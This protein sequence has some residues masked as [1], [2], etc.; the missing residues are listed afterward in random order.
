MKTSEY[1]ISDVE[2]K[3]LNS[4]RK[5]HSGLEFEASN[6]LIHELFFKQHAQLFDR[7][8]SP[9]SCLPLANVASMLNG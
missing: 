7:L 2:T 8:G 6:M 5:S 9:L 4:V 3:K 1:K